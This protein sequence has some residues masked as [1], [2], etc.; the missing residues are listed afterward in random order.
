MNK[1]SL[2]PIAVGRGRITKE[3]EFIFER[4]GG[5]D[6]DEEAGVLYVGGFVRG[7]GA[8]LPLLLLR[9]VFR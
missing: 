9:D 3:H 4:E 7:G 5:D 8:F 6:G 2:V 1:I